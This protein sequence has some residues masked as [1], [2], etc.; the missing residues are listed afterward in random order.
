MA[1]IW[2]EYN[3]LVFKG[4]A[5]EGEVVIPAMFNNR[6]SKKTTIELIKILNSAENYDNRFVLAAQQ[7]LDQRNKKDL[8]N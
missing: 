1:F 7:E 4:K 5:K 2:S 3:I 6:V 8:S